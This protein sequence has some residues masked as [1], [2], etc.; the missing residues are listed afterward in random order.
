MTFNYEEIA[1]GFYDKIFDRPDGIRKFWHWHKFDSVLR[2]IKIEKQP[3]NLLDVGCFSGSFS[4][5]FLNPEIIKS[6]SIDVLKEQIEYANEKYGACNKEFAF[7]K[8]FKQGEDLLKNK[9][10]DVVTFIEVIE[11]LTQEQIGDFFNMID[12]V[13][14]QGSQ[15][16]ITTPN[17]VSLWPALEIILNLIS[18]VKYEEQHIT[19]MNRFNI[20]KKLTR[21]YPPFSKKWDVELISTSHFLTPFISVLNFDM[22]KNMSSRIPVDAWGNPFGSLVILKLIKIDN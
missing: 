12:K 7:Y 9:L 1:P 10:F 21:I 4:G 8:D 17:Y 11:H 5:R 2:S 13:T 6:F 15:L 14:K 18:D 22:A 19:K 20:V 16:I 3:L